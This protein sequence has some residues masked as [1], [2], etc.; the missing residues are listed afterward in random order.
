MSDDG[1]P[2]IAGLPGEPATWPA[3]VR[4]CLRYVRRESPTESELAEWWVQEVRPVVE[5]EADELEPDE[6][7]ADD[8]EAAVERR[9]AF[10][11]SADLLDQSTTPVAL[12]RHGRE[13]L[14]SHD[15]TVL[16]EGLAASLPGLETVLGALAI[17]PLTDVEVADLLAAERDVASVDVETARSHRRWL[18]ALG[19]CEHDDGVTDITPR[20][21]RVVDAAGGPRP[22]GATVPDEESALDPA[23]RAGGGSGAAPDDEAPDPGRVQA[24]R[25]GPTGQRPEPTR[26][27]DSYAGELK[28]LYD[29]TCVLCGDRRRLAD[30]E[31]YSCVHHPMPP[32]EPHGG[33]ERPENA[34]VVCPNHRADLER[35]VVTIDPQTLEIDHAHDESLTGRRLT[36]AGDH[37]PGAEYLAYHD[38]VMAAVPD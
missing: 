8:P 37:E 25:V 35:G 30:G 23:D 36:T 6:L 16:Y 32:G 1:A 19:F 17:R 20:G 18:A 34:L 24:A 3:T 15:E 26:E 10:I 9:L 28:S 31:G 11:S 4:D 2:A 7:E 33:P 27:G 21:R 22:P 38:A 12:G 14:D 13:Y 29:H 5:R